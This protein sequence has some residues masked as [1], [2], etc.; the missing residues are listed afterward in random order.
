[1]PQ[2]ESE[3]INTF[4]LTL[5]HKQRNFTVYTRTGKS[6]LLFKV[7]GPCVATSCVFFCMKKS[8]MLKY[9]LEKNDY[10]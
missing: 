4:L 10:N 1:M 6:R 2:Y 8:Y 3:F 5:I 9:G 7:S